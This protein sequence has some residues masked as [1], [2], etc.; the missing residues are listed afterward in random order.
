M[1]GYIYCYD[2]GKD[3]RWKRVCGSLN[4]YENVTS[5]GDIRTGYPSFM[6]LSPSTECLFDLFLLVRWMMNVI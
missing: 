4:A 2:Y 3:K 5:L 6:A 1:G